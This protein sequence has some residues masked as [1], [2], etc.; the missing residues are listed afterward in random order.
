MI[1]RYTK[2]LLTVIAVAL[3]AIV[4]QQSGAQAQFG[5]ALGCDGSVQS[6]CFIRLLN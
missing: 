5:I 2:I 3:V 6:P 4:F 1:D